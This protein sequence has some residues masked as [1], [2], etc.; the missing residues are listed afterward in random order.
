[1]KIQQVIV[2]GQNQVELQDVEFDANLGPDQFL[3]KTESTFI[4]AG[5]EL[6]NYTGKEPMV[7]EPGS[8]C[9]YPWR[10]GYANV[11]IVSEVGKDVT[12]VEL[13]QRVFTCGAHASV[14]KARQDM[15]AIEVPE[16]LNSG[17]AAAA[18]MAGVA[19]TSIVVA[20]IGLSPTVVVFGLG[21]VGNLAAQAF[22]ILGARVIGVDLM[23]ERR[24]L[25][26]RCGIP[27]TFGGT[28]EEI[29][30]A[31]ADATGG[32]MAEITVDATGISPVIPQA[33]AV[34]ANL[35]QCILLGSPRAPFEGNMTEVFS[36]IHLRNIT[37][38]GALEWILPE[39]SP[40]ATYGGKT[41]PLLSSYDKMSMIFDWIQ[42]GEM[43]IDPIISHRLPAQ[44]VKAGYDGLLNEASTYTGVVLEW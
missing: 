10:S 26:E 5:T 15:L 13:G 43:K 12:R 38:R 33:I 30:Q 24:E 31:I 37:M 8:W 35:G 11:G 3:V 22:R 44:Q 39:Y 20:D 28:S 19:T 32:A 1:M 27:M 42:R 29:H 25:A 9:A 2:T 7:F 16:G 21:M 36:A 40:T 23:P 6:A 4:S 17:V 14:I 18:R 41:Q 34:T